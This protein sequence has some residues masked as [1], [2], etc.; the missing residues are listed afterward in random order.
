MAPTHRSVRSGSATCVP[1]ARAIRPRHLPPGAALLSRS[2]PQAP[3]R[4][5]TVRPRPPSRSPPHFFI[6]LLLRGSFFVAFFQK[7]TQGAPSGRRVSPSREL[8]LCLVVAVVAAAAAA[9]RASSQLCAP[10]P[11]PPPPSPSPPPPPASSSA[12]LW[13]PAGG[14]R[15]ALRMPRCPGARWRG[16]R[17]QAGPARSCAWRARGQTEGTRVGSLK[18]E[19]AAAHAGHPRAHLCPW[20]L[21]NTLLGQ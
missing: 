14:P 4:S 16:A 10:P 1:G 15:S 21:R 19:D 20:C 9:S 6:F 13:P 8:F 12:R 5:G 7:Q 18:A 17:L 2:E 3:C 11:P